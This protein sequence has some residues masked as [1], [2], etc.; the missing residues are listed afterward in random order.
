MLRAI[1]VKT[2]LVRNE[3]YLFISLSCISFFGFCFLGGTSSFEGSSSKEILL[4]LIMHVN[5]FFA[6]FNGLIAS[7]LL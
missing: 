4:A 2:V 3:E 6:A 5:D 7:D 1:T